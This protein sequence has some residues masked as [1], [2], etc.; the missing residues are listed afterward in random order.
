MFVQEI[1]V[2]T[3][4][5]RRKIHW[6]KWETLCQPKSEGGMGFKDLSLFNDALLT[7]QVRLPHNKQSLCYHIFKARFFPNFSIME[8]TNSPF[9]MLGEAF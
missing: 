2:G 9:L 7:K 5:D 3:R 1:L 4:G 8:A 6:V